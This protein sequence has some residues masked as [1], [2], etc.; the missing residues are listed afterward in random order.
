MPD[1][2]SHITTSGGLLTQAVV[3]EL[4]E[5][6]VSRSHMDAPSFALPWTPAP[7]TEN[8]L[9]DDIATAWELLKERWDSI[10][11]EPGGLDALD[12]SAVRRRWLIPLCS[13]LDFSPQYQQGHLRPTDDDALRFPISH[14]GW[15]S[16]KAPNP[17]P[18]HLLPATQ[19]LDER[20][21]SGRGPKAKSPHDMVQ[22]FLNVSPDDRWALLSNGR[23]LR[24]LR[25]YH[26]TFSKGYIQFDLESIFETRAYADFRA[27]YRLG[28]ASRFR[29]LPAPEDDSEAACPLESIHQTARAAGVKVGE[30]LR[31]QVRTAIEH[32]ANGFLQG[33]A[34]L[35]DLLQDD[36][37][38]ARAFYRDVL[39]VVYR[40]LFLLFAE[41]R[42]LVP[43][44][45]APRADLYWSD[46]SLTALREQA[47][48]GVPR[49]DRHTDLWQGL[50][51]TFKM[52]RKGTEALGVFGYNGELFATGPDTYLEGRACD[53]T[54]L[55]QAI[56]ALTLIEDEGVLQRISYVDL[57]VDELGSVYESLL[58]FTPRVTT[59]PETIDGDEFAAGTFVLDPRGLERKQS[60]SYYTDDSLVNELIKSA[61]LPVMRDRLQ[62]AGLP[63]RSVQ[64]DAEA[65]GGL[66]EDYA[67]LDA[68]ARNAGTAA[69]LD[70][71]IVDPAAGSG[72]FLVA[73]N[74]VMG[75]EIA[76]LRTGDAYP[77]ERTIRQATRDVLAQCIYAVDLNPMAVELCKVSLWINA[78]VDNE[79]LNFLDHHIKCGNSLI[80]ATPDLLKDGVPYEAFD[81]TR[82]GT[83]REQAKE[84]RKRNRTE[85]RESKDGIGVQLGAFAEGMT[86]DPGTAYTAG[87]FVQL[88]QAN[89]KKAREV[90]R[91]WSQDPSRQRAK[92]EADAWTAAFFWPID[93]YTEWAPTYGEVFR[94]QREGPGAIPAEEAERIKSLA[95]RHRFF[96]WHLEFPEVFANGEHPERP[97]G[98]EGSPQNGQTDGQAR[99]STSSG[100]GFDVV[101]GNPPWERIKLQEK[102]FFAVKAPDIA[103][104]STAAKRKKKIKHLKADGDPLY[105]E[106][107]QAQQ[108][109][110]AF[111]TYLRESGRYD[112]T[113]VGDVN[114]YQIFA[115]LVRQ[116]IDATGRVGVIVPSG[117]ATDY[118]T[119][120]FFN[121]LVDNRE[122]VSLYDFENRKPLF[123]G[124]DSRMKF[125][126]LTLTG[127]G[128]PQPAI[129]FAFFLTQTEHLSDTDR[130]FTLSPEELYAINPNTGTCPT[131]RSKRDAELTKKLYDAAL[132]LINEPEDENPWGVSF[133]TM[134]HM[135]GDSD[136]FHT[137]EELEAEGFVLEGNRFVRG[138][139]V[140]LPLYEAKMFHQFDHRFATYETTEDS[141]D[142]TPEEHVQAQKQ[143]VP[144]YW[145]RKTKIDRGESS[146]LAFRD[147]AR[148]T[149]V[150]TAML[151]F[152]PPMGV[153]H[154]APL[155]FDGHMLTNTLCLT[156]SANSFCVDYAVRQKL[157]G[158]HLTY[159]ILKQL[160]VH[161]PERYTPE[162]LEYI[163]PRVLE[164]TY[165]AWDLAAFADDVW[166]ESSDTL[167]EAIKTQWQSNTEATGGGHRGKRMPVWLHS[168]PEDR[169]T[170]VP[171]QHTDP[172]PNP[173]FPHEPFMWN[174]ERRTHL[175]ADLDGLYGHLYGLERNELAYIL[176]TFPIVK[177]KDKAEHGEYRT[178]RLVLEAYDRLAGSELVSASNSGLTTL[179]EDDE[180]ALSDDSDAH[181]D[182]VEAELRA[183]LGDLDD[184]PSATEDVET[185]TSEVERV[186]RSDAFRIGVRKLYG[187]Q[188]CIC[189]ADARGTGDGSSIVDAAHIVPRHKGGPDDP[190][191]GLAL[192]KNHH[193]AYDQG[194]FHI[195]PD[196][197]AVQVRPNLPNDRDY[198]FLKA[199]D[200]EPIAEPEV[201]P[202]R[203]RPHE[204]FLRWRAETTKEETT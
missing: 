99:P 82:S 141:R 121:A 74:N 28:H 192:C 54:R 20:H 184:D 81:H 137:R 58:D 5:A 133:S 143:V 180:D 189:G 108:F 127:S 194:L 128:A 46:Y 151:T 177:R 32:L 173:R 138:E 87:D 27:L 136:L 64:G 191:N 144:R 97:G 103:G 57:G 37:D 195:D 96:H 122:L 193:W 84:M 150:R 129:D 111:S 179:T 80:G 6:A 172:F 7:T 148:N 116:V 91:S 202:E 59:D 157:S 175:R 200:G 66:L 152:L 201:E 62:R 61:L 161:P 69:L 154:T 101:L 167:R 132:V 1:T 178:K 78:S 63:V 182:G 16:P 102:E 60:G 3:D 55:L 67:E 88:A 153:G 24:L 156:A 72:H 50:T 9:N 110:E 140:F 197:R 100:P 162:L 114:L 76:R 181:R 199:Y 113:A 196:E 18:V 106:Y 17:P 83:H 92:L 21:G 44:A 155:I 149:D 118:Y 30:K 13:L 53:N 160:P 29:I 14:R 164:L 115:G 68:S 163:V 134:F 130:H 158:T 4:R 174:E 166:S 188:C 43:D 41:Q 70:M 38:A 145:I 124:V 19:L 89:P 15:I 36:I 56:R 109:S 86:T 139:E 94:L 11:Q 10:Q 105:D 112:L 170:S 117:I 95:D 147:I 12:T 146:W 22:L 98:V 25:N 126:L 204:V 35:I 131:F 176:D 79:P 159:S 52:V 51:T 120:D 48:S 31:P 40:M 171:Y 33:D 47:E 168:V 165:T 65:A 90:Y 49:S 186:R 203:Y 85:R 169:F 93:A 8:A 104:A 135:S 187:H 77:H 190:R 75:A 73:A 39:R 34:E 123:H 42:G 45:S 125:C 183:L 107:Q 71:D 142:V 119:Q 26:H 2:P 185:E 198:R 23:T